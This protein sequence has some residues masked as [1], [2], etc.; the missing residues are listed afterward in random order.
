MK[1]IKYFSFIITIFTP[2]AV[3][4]NILNGL[5]LFLYGIDTIGV[6]YY[7]ATL[8]SIIFL[9]FLVIMNI[10]YNLR[11]NKV[12]LENDN[13]NISRHYLLYAK[14][15][16]FS[17]YGTIIITFG[18]ILGVL[19]MLPMFTGLLIER[20]PQLLINYSD[21]IKLYFMFGIIILLLFIWHIIII[22]ISFLYFS[23]YIKELYK[24][25]ESKIR[26]YCILYF[27]PIINII[28]LMKSGKN[29]V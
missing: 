3:L 21:D 11:Y 24:D 26:N 10:V 19:F 27:I 9:F 13:D 17:N 29:K 12:F 8:F 28:I 1:I 20:F 7:F 14:M 2:I 22:L 25:N 23:R 4:F 5:G 18:P 6:I 15:S 16:L